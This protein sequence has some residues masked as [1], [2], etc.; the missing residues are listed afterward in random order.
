MNRQLAEIAGVKAVIKARSV[1]IGKPNPHEHRSEADVVILDRPLKKEIPLKKCRHE[2]ITE[3]TRC[4]DNGI[5]V[6]WCPDCEAR[7]E[8]NVEDDMTDEAR[9]ITNG[10]HV[11]VLRAIKGGASDDR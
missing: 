2:N 1:S 7:F 11:R 9:V 8:E 4:T 3:I 6:L 10:E 5:R